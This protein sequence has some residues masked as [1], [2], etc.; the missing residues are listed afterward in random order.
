ML[1]SSTAAMMLGHAERGAIADLTAVI[2]QLT[3]DVESLKREI[4]NGKS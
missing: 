2:D 1:G 4:K 3:R